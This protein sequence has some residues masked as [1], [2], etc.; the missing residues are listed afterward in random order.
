[1]SRNKTLPSGRSP[2]TH[3]LSA[4]TPF[5]PAKPSQGRTGGGVEGLEGKVGFTGT[6]TPLRMRDTDHG[7]RGKVGINLQQR[8]FLLVAFGFCYWDDNS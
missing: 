1:M 6:N 5:R 2:R 7:E 8:G 4:V 3:G